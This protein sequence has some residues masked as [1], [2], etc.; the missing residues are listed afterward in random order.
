MV[1]QKVLMKAESLVALMAAKKAAWT[2]ELMAYHW[3]GL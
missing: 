3:V 2:G 1:A